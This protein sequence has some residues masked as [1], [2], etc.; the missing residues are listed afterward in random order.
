M[1][2]QPQHAAQLRA[3]CL[4]QRFLISCHA[5]KLFNLV[6]CWLQYWSCSAHVLPVHS[7]DGSYAA[8]LVS[9]HII[10]LC[11]TAGEQWHR[12]ADSA[13]FNNKKSC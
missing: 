7:W 3:D 10:L 1:V 6:D 13:F 11:A 2:L 5:S 9:V 4:A 8:S 12:R